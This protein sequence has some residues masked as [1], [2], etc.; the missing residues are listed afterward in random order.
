MRDNSS[1]RILLCFAA[2]LVA[3]APALAQVG[4]DVMVAD[5]HN[6]AYWG[7][8]GDLHS[9]SV[10]TVSCNIGDVDLRWEANNEWH[11]VIGQNLY[12]LKDGRIEQL[13]LSWLKHGFITIN[14]G[15]CGVCPPGGTGNHLS[16]GCS[17]PYGAG[18]NGSRSRLGPRYEVNASTGVYPYPYDNSAPVPNLLTRRIIVDHEDVNP[19]QNA[20]ALYFVEGQ[21]VA[22]DDAA[23]G[24]SANNQSYRRVTV[25]N[26]FNIPMRGATHQFDPAIQA[27]YDHGNG[28]NTPDT[29]VSVVSVDVPDDGR[30][31]VGG[32]ATDNGDGTWHYEY[33][34]QNLTSH[35]SGGSFT[36]QVPLGANVSGVGFH[37]VNYHS[38]EPWLPDD[39]NMSIGA[40]D[41]TWTSPE[42][43]A[44]NPNSNALRWGTL[45]NFWFDVDAPPIVVEVDL[46]L[47][48]PGT[49]NSVSIR[50]I[51]PNPESECQSCDMNCDGLIDA[52][53]IEPFIDL[54]FNGGVPC[55]ECTGDV[56]GDGVI[57]A[58]DIEP[59]IGCLFP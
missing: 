47:F 46:G 28:V 38:G 26:N 27:W 44:Q 42:T 2:V 32:K 29:G 55:N 7:R 6:T 58:G 20:G 45:Y 40:T 50:T 9:Y 1:K 13:G 23:A 57:D 54:L 24:N 4:P 10:G 52:T 36:V 41:I 49:P 33:A 18:L 8:I 14:S 21:Y 11:P 34:I 15:I 48:R 19:A 30:F 12:R 17:D 53:D 35:R 39:W 25:S 31:W 22:Q 16:P 37:D 51:G 56:N 5:L 59:F 43:H 3:G